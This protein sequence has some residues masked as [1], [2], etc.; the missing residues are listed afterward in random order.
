MYVNVRFQGDVYVRPIPVDD[1]TSTARLVDSVRSTFGI[2]TNELD[3]YVDPQSEEIPLENPLDQGSSLQSAGIS[4]GSHLVVQTP[5]TKCEVF[6]S[7]L[8][9]S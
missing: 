7:P 3:L 8:F 9:H 4:A 5:L 2:A 1:S 6:M